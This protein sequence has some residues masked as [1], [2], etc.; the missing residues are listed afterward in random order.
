[1]PNSLCI[2]C[3]KVTEDIHTCT[4]SKRYRAGMIEGMQWA[5]DVV[6]STLDPNDA[7]DIKI[8]N[9]EEAINGKNYRNHE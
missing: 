7:I 5:L 6:T 4:P 9:Y 1:M 2:R 8:G 3:D